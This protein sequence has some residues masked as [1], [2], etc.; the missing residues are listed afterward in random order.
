MNNV[1]NIDSFRTW[2]YSGGSAKSGRSPRREISSTRSQGIINTMRSTSTSNTSDIIIQGIIN[3]MQSRSS[4]NVDI[5]GN[6]SI[7]TTR[8]VEAVAISTTLDIKVSSMPCNV[9]VAETPGILSTSLIDVSIPRSLFCF[10]SNSSAPWIIP[11]WL[12]SSG[13]FVSSQHVLQ[14][15]LR[16]CLWPT[17]SM[18]SLGSYI[19]LQAGTDPSVY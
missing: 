1:T 12:F 8:D 13:F 15:H 5:I 2:I 16:R 11:I 6:Q 18:P 3:T 17:A 9:E 4:S 19:D 14:I 10:M 7:S